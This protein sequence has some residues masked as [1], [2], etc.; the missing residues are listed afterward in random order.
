MDDLKTHFDLLAATK[1]FPIGTG[2]LASCR[3]FLKLNGKSFICQMS[4]RAHYSEDY[5]E[6]QGYPGTYY[7]QVGQVEAGE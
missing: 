3:S 5:S 4:R 7:R 6:G 1:S 2:F